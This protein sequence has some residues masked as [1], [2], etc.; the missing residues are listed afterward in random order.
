MK[1]LLFNQTLQILAGSE[2]YTLTL[3]AELKRLG[4]EVTAYSP[5]LGIIAAKLEGM[6]VKCVNEL[7]G[8]GNAQIQPFNPILVESES[9]FDIAIGAHYDR[10]REVR[11][12]FPNLPIIAICHGIIHSNPETG[13]IYPEHPVTDMRIEQYVAVSEE[14]QGLLKEAYGIDSVVI[15]NMFD[16]SR[17]KK[18]GKI[19][20]KPETILV[21]SNYW[22]V[23]DEIN[24]IIKEVAEN[25]NA[26]FI[27][28]GANFA[29]TYE[30]DE[31]IKQADIVFGMGRSVMEGVCAGKIGVVHGRWG[32]GGVVTKETYDTL[33]L[34]N[35][36]GRPVKGQGKLL[37][38]KDIIAQID[39]AWDQKSVDATHAI[40][41]KEHDVKVIAKKFLD[42]A[43]KLIK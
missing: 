35:F 36:S 41:K 21:S 42:I 6:G 20:K 40:I 14:V 2:T 12:K 38:A 26:K 29:T 15:R 43:E 11:Q 1:I 30:T 4:H 22:G 9:N 33:K 28:I 25:Y 37:P 32:T 31:I 8:D 23:E 17:F 7:V 16:L 34:T 3:A 5:H 39:L 10:T 18:E 13:E 19:K 27:G 24:K